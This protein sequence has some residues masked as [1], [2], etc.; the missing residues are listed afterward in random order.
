MDKAKKEI[1]TLL[2]AQWENGFE[3]LANQ[4]KNDSIELV[5]KVGFYEYFDSRK[6]VYKNGTLGYGGNNFS[7]T[8]ALIIDFLDK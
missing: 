5:E 7:W 6:D 8:A 3:K 4:I 2:D 1:S